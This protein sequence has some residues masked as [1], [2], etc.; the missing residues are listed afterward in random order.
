MKLAVIFPGIGYHCDKPLLYFAKKAAKN[1]GYELL[2]A[3]YGNLPQNAKGDKEKMREAFEL[4]LGQTEEILSQA[5]LQDCESLLFISKSIGTAA[6]AAYQHKHK[7]SPANIFYTPLPET[8]S[9]GTQNGIA[10][11]GTADPWVEDKEELRRKAKA[12]GITLFEYTGANHSLE[13][14]DAVESARIISGV[15]ERSAEYISG[16]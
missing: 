14:G 2:E 9:F 1:A 8:F 10:F 16:L 13:T 3:G 5:A 15:I 4:A 6:A 7:L 12:A 11:T